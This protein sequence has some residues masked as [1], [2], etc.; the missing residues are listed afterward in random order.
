MEAPIAFKIFSGDLDST[1]IIGQHDLFGNKP[2]VHGAKLTESVLCFRHHVKI[3]S[4]MPLRQA[5][6]WH[7][8][9]AAS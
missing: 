8:Q 6:R 5:T 3:A 7:P 1:G 9:G 4:W 2:D